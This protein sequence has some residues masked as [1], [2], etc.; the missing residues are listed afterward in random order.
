MPVSK[1]CARAIAK[2]DV[3]DL[4]SLSRKSPN[5]HLV[6]PRLNIET[7]AECLLVSTPHFSSVFLLLHPDRSCDHD[8]LSRALD[9]GPK[10]RRCHRHSV[11]VMCFE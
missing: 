11:R 6:Q 8:D 9:P 7:D 3:V 10:Y 2:G 1:L 5:D 4:K